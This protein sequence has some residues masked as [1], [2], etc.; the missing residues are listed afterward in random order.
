MK[1][2]SLFLAIFVFSFS[3]NA[4]IIN[5]PDPNFKNKLLASTTSNSIALNASGISIKIDTNTNGEIEVSE[6]Q[7]VF[8]LNASTSTINTTNDIFDMSGIQNF[9]N[10]KVLKCDGNQLTSLDLTGMINLEEVRCNDNQL[11]NFAISGLSNLKIIDCRDN[12]LTSFSPAGFLNLQKLD[13]SNNQISSLTFT[14]NP[15]LITLYCNNNSLTTLD[16]TASTNLNVVGCWSNQLTNLNVSGLTHIIELECGDNNL[17][18]L[19]VS[20]LSTLGIL[21][22]GGNSLTSI[23]V[24]S[25]SSLWVLNCN[26]NPL[27]AINVSGL[28]ALRQLFISNTSVPTIDCSQSGV[29]Q[30]F[31]SNNPN[32]V[33]INVQNNHFSSSD[34]DMLYFAFKF[35]NNPALTSIC[36]DN[37]EQNNLAY[38]DYNSTGNVV[39]YTGPTCSTVLMAVDGFEKGS[40]LSLYPNPANHTITLD[41]KNNNQANSIHIY[42]VLG[43]LVQSVPNQVEDTSITFDVSELKTGTY[44]INVISDKGKSTSKFIKL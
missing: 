9:T 35:E 18:S 36:V 22:C 12:H 21:G 43:Q 25:L 20:G 31:A 10:L 2:L 1:N 27:T 8:A 16:L 29:E 30:L 23:D 4:Q 14:N 44:F 39:V 34:P 41:L 37:G 38:T 28:T 33:N 17:G 26:L 19:N 24:S 11:S 40:A 7:N 32:L 6:I 3:L 5:I 15:N 13:I 42:N